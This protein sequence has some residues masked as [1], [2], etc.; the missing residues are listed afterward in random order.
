MKSRKENADYI[1]YDC[2]L[3]DELNKYGVPHIIGS[4]KMDLMAWNDLDIDI[5]NDSM[6]LEKLYQLTSYVLEKYRPTWYEAK[7]ER[8]SDE[9]TVWFLGFEATVNGELW[10]LDLWFFDKETIKSAESYCNEIILKT[11]QNPPAKKAI[12]EI[13]KNLISKGL[14]SFDKYSSLDVYK[15]VLEQNILNISDFWENYKK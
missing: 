2:G 6:S 4:Y 8:N 13:K 12:I 15:A 10:N 9:K 11:Y 1:L 7:E 5:E 3:L 14:Y